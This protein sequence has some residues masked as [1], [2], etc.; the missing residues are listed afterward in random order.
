[1]VATWS[2]RSYSVCKEGNGENIISQRVISEGPPCEVV[3]DGLQAKE[4]QEPN[5]SQKKLFSGVVNIER[6]NASST[7]HPITD[8]SFR[9]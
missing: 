9:S 6:E 2:G 5:Q 1:M 3:R 4:R 8:Q 7:S